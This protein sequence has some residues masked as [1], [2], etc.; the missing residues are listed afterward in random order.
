MNRT[1]IVK[2]RM[3]VYLV[4]GPQGSGKSTQA[5]L[6]SEY[7]K[8]PFFDSGSQLRELSQSDKSYARKLHSTIA[9]GNLV[10]NN[11]LRD[12][13]NDFINNHNCSNGMVIDGFPRT[14]EQVKLLDELSKKYD[15]N[16][17]SFYV[18]ISDNTAKERLS[19][20]YKLIN[21]K[22]VFR[23][24]DKPS[25]V[26]RRLDLFKKETIPVIKWLR[27]HY[28]VFDVDGEPDR[29]SVFTQMLKILKDHTL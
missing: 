4:F 15:W 22:K 9:G 23:D 24:D 6:L 26:S 5:E 19:N 8:L 10:S 18:G 1:N 12:I 25:I 14:I 20:R 27:T 3:P 21:G 17:M 11:I 7:L 16:V 29:K 13:F 2:D 28:V